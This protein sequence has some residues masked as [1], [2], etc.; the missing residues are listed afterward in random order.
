LKSLDELRAEHDGIKVMLN[1]L[2][3][4]VDL[5]ENGAN[6]DTGHLDQ[7]MEFITVFVDKCHHGKE[8]QLL[9]PA[10][11]A[12]GVPQ[13]G[14]PVGVMLREHASGRNTVQAMSDALANYK[15][16]D[17]NA[18]HEFANYARQ[19]IN[20]LNNHIDKENNILYPMG[21]NLL[22]GEI[23]ARLTEGF[24]SVEREQIGKGKHEQ[25]HEML[26]RLKTHYL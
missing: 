7:I 26:H 2:S 25:F 4:I 14:G 15:V 18:I 21:E 22:S 11:T 13:E 20:M 9:F 8:E 1:I 24:E 5:A 6:I 10:L 16:G 23:D 19:Y 17:K 3:A 12:V